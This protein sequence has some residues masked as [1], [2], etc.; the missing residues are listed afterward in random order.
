[1]N[2]ANLQVPEVDLRTSAYGP[3]CKTSSHDALRC[4]GTMDG[5]RQG[6]RSQAYAGIW[7]RPRTPH[8]RRPAWPATQGSS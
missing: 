3:F 4:R 5:A 6:R 1:L 7:L 2:G 8:S